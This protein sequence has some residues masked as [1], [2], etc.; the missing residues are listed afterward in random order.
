MREHETM[1]MRTRLEERHTQQR[2]EK[3]REGDGDD[4]YEDERA[5]Q[6]DVEAGMGTCVQRARAA[7][8]TDG[9]NMRYS[10]KHGTERADTDENK[11]HRYQRACSWPDGRSQK[12]GR[13]KGMVHSC[14]R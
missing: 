3:K 6:G 11:T 1:R 8:E 13:R 14:P 7:S 4:E 12:H 10:R 5:V 9:I 2:G